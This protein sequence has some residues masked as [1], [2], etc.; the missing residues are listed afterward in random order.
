MIKFLTNNIG[1]IIV[2]A[3]VVLIVAGIVVK[4]VKDKKNGASVCGGDCSKCHGC[5]HNMDS[6]NNN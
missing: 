5:S 4:M 2:L 6:P 3:V 1:T